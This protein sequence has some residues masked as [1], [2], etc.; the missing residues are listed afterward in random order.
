MRQVTCRRRLDIGASLKRGSFATAEPTRV[1]PTRGGRQSELARRVA[2]VVE[3]RVL[4]RVQ[5]APHTESVRHN[6]ASPRLA[7]REASRE[8]IA[9][10][11]D[12]LETPEEG[13][14]RWSCR[15]RPAGGRER[16]VRRE[17]RIVEA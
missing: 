8:R 11:L 3:A 2:A 1:V 6:E 4:R 12:R 9:W 13:V 10:G 15:T 5:H 7:Q 17:L 16:R 14:M